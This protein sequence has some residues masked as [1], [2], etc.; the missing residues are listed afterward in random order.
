[1]LSSPFASPPSGVN[2]PVVRNTLCVLGDSF[3]ARDMAALVSNVYS[4]LPYGIITLT[5]MLLQGAFTVVNIDGV[6]GTNSASFITRLTASVLAFRPRYA[7]IQG[8]VNEILSGVSPQTLAQSI[9]NYSS[10]FQ[11][12]NAAGTTVITNTVPPFQGLD[13]TA[14]RTQWLR[15]NTWLMNVAPTLYDVIVLRQDYQYLDPALLT[16]QPNAAFLAIDP[17]HP[18]VFNAFQLAQTNAATLKAHGIGVIGGTPFLSGVGVAGAEDDT[19][20]PNPINVGTAGILVSGNVTGVVSNTMQVGTTSN[21]GT[22]VCSKV[23]RT[24]GPGS[25][26]Q[27]VYTPSAS[28][29]TC[30]YQNF[31]AAVVLGNNQIGD[32]VSFFQEYEIDAGT[33]AANV[34]WVGAQLQFVGA[35]FNSHAF[36]ISSGLDN[37]GVTNFRGVLQTPPVA[38]PAGTTGLYMLGIIFG[39]GAG[40]PVTVRFGQTAFR[41]FSRKG[42]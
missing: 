13:T 14:K 34:R 38:I 3:T 4:V 39:A 30:T 27:I 24:D 2:I 28:N 40:L 22:A 5:N 20:H 36:P 7:Y 9:A 35:A 18:A 42:Q 16:C 37:I 11:Q 33:T 31:G 41:N 29:Q 23:A 15:F 1:M 26:Q 12:C 25:W 32:V 17:T 10:M 8:T 6:S 21:L 19:V